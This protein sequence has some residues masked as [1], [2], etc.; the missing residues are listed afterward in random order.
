MSDRR[1]ALSAALA[2]SAVPIVGVGFFGLSLSALVVVY[3]IELEID[4][5]VAALRGT[6][7][8]RPPEHDADLLLLGAFRHKRGSRGIDSDGVGGCPCRRIDTN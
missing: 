7:A 3:W 6:F 5:G 2:T 1:T 8:Q 4:L